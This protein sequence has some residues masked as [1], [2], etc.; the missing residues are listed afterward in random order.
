MRAFHDQQGRRWEAVVGRESY[1]I[2][3]LLFLPAGG[4][5][6]R[7][8]VMASSTRLEAHRELDALS[9]IELCERLARSQSWDSDTVF[10]D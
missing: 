8:A 1:G 5:E 7:K 4:G 2:Q 9:D 10:P 3:V 6:V